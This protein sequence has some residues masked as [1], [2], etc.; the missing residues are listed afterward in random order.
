M[1][2]QAAVLRMRSVVERAVLLAI[3]F[4]GAPAYGQEMTLKEVS[5][6]AALAVPQLTPKT[7]AFIDQRPGTPTDTTTVLQ[8]FDAWAQASPVQKRLLGLYPNYVEPP[9]SAS[10]SSSSSSSASKPQRER[11]FM[12][13]AQARFVVERPP[14][15]IDPQRYV[16]LSFLGRLDPAITHKTIA[17]SDAIPVKERGSESNRHPDRHWCES[18]AKVLCVQSRY[19][20]EGRLP[21][22]VRLANKLRE[23]RRKI[24]EYID[25]QSELRVMPA[26]EYEQ[27]ALRELTG[28]DTPVSGALEQ[29]MFHANQ[30]V[31]FGKLLAVFQAHPTDPKRTIVTTFVALAVKAS[32]F[33]MKKEFENV[34]VL[35]NLTP[36]QV[37]LGNSS[38]NSGNS[39]SAGLP[40]YARSRIKAIAE[41]IAKD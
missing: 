31:Q 36:A 25:F 38:F 6:V 20:L 10:S 11:L 12:Y 7:I 15:S 37:L 21:M 27:P 24:T 28:L 30:I 8:P 33:E 34:P 13:V 5:S 35:K 17:P 32:L 9:A 39:I 18:A 23:G 3:I 26:A 1:G 19:Q 2:T 16:D 29:S 41:I 4:A 14:A 22:G 40:K